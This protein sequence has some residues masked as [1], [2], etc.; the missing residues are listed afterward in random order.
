MRAQVSEGLSLAD[1]AKS[2]MWDFYTDTGRLPSS[3][4]SAGLASATSIAGNYVTSVEISSGI[5]VVTYGNEA[6][7]RLQDQ[8]LQLSAATT[9]G[10]ITWSCTGGTLV[11]RYRP[12]SCR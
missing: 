12:A 6:N 9:G 8:T 10:S 7:A 5:V 11:S 1:G 4:T 3:N 2:A